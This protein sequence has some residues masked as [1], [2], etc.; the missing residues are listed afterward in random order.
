MLC[1]ENNRC[2]NFSGS[3]ILVLIISSILPNL[4]IAVLFFKEGNFS[5]S[6]CNFII[7]D[8]CNSSTSLV[9]CNSKRTKLVPNKSKVLGILVFPNGCDGDCLC[10]D[11][12]YL[13]GCI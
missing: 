4:S 12:E 13:C 2:C 1:F 7:S 3:F 6:D 11:G 5:N 10:C 9:D 8:A